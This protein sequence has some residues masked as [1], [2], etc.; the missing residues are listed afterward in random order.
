MPAG[1]ATG[2]ILRSFREARGA[3][4]ASV[5]LLVAGPMAE[6]LARDLA[7]GG[8]PGVVSTSGRPEDA[9][10]LVVVLAG[11]PAAEEIDLARRAARANVAVAAVQLDPAQN[12]EVPY[13]LAT[14]VVPCAPGQG[15]PVA[16]VAAVLA[17]RLGGRAYPLAAALP[18]LREE[19]SAEATRQAATLNALVALLPLS[20]AAHFP[21]MALN[22]L[23]L[24]LGVSV[25][26]G[27]ELGREGPLDAAAVLAAGLALRGLARSLAP[28]LP[29]GGRLARAAIAAGGTLGL[30]ELA[31]RRPSL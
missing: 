6:Q 11:A 13:V 16:G 28:Q 21:T 19:I 8:R 1:L 9:D 18:A 26:N 20:S 7:A 12:A 23:R 15:F 25:A 5:S 17:R 3:A 24:V 31:A 2:A 14:D 4:G 30:G 27:R 29:V 10:A 22:Q